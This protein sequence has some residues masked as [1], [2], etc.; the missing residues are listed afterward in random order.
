MEGLQGGEGVGLLCSVIM[1]FMSCFPTMYNIHIDWS[2]PWQHCKTLPTAEWTKRWCSSESYPL[3]I[4]AQKGRGQLSDWLMKDVLHM[5]NMTTAT[6]CIQRTYVVPKC[7]GLYMVEEGL[8]L[9][10]WD[11]NTS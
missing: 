7:Y 3:G 4:S 8:C 2:C 6:V 5:S 1:V 9:H 11:D 10:W